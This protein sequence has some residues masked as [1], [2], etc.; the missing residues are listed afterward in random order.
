MQ[1]SPGMIRLS[2]IGFNNLN[3]TFLSNPKMAILYTKI[4]RLYPNPYIFCFAE[5]NGDDD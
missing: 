5:R 3:E 4:Y 1:L 2:Q